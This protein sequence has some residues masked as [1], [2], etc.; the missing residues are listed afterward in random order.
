MDKIFK[1]MNRHYH[2]IGIGGIGMSGIAKLLLKRKA[3][4]SGSD[5]KENRATLELKRLGAQVFI[6]HALGNIE[7]AD[8]IIYSS[9][10]NKD[11][12]EIRE[13]KT[14]GIPV[15]R[16]AEAL[17]ELMRE[18]VV[19]TVTGSHGKTTTSSMI[20]YLLIEAGLCPSIAVGGVLKNIDSNAYSGDGKFFVA[21]ADESD[22]TFLYYRPNYSVITNIDHEH[23]DYY[24]SFINELSAFKKFINQT[25][26]TGCVFCCGDDENLKNLLNDYPYRRVLF[27]LNGDSDIYAKNIEFRGLSSEFDCFAKNKFIARFHLPLGGKHNVSNA[28][29]VI[30]L[31]LEMKLDL[32]VAKRSLRNYKGS[33]RRLDIKFQDSNY[34]VLD[35]YAHHPTEIKATLSALKS[36]NRKRIIAVFQP[37]RFSRTKLL[38]EEFG[39]SFSAADCIIVTD[40]YAASEPPLEGIQASAVYEKIKKYNP[41]KEVYYALRE[42]IVPKLLK[43]I[44]PRDLVITLGAGDINKVNDELVRGFTG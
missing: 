12:P 21:E 5:V 26:K 9:V 13:A 1:E 22:G 2:L 7:G 16:R 44:E 11:N 39:R 6:G 25:E 18:K 23:L 20:S 8:L 40:I 43:M 15:I 28:L 36:L 42:E 29:A 27:G 33:G 14:I 19:I 38:L 24:G 34:M 31:S 35:D 17:V 32:E 37:H 10:I 41:D 4:V 30:A 3:K